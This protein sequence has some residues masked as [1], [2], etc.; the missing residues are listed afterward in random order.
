MDV[1]EIERGNAYYCSCCDELLYL[2][3]LRRS[4]I[5]IVSILMNRGVIVKNYALYGIKGFHAFCSR[6]CQDIW[7]ELMLT[8]EQRQKG[9]T[10]A[11]ALRKVMDESKD[12]ICH[13]L[14]GYSKSLKEGFEDIR[15]GKL[16]IEGRNRQEV[17]DNLRDEFLKRFRR[18]RKDR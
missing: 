3:R 6:E 16:K 12:E 1:K 15:S 2:D 7:S 5:E 14:A 13:N 11:I 8:P 4:E 10:I 17:I 18:S 9:D